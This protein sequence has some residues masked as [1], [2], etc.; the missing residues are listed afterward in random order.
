MTEETAKSVHRE[1]TSLYLC[2]RAIANINDKLDILRKKFET[3]SSPKSPR[4]DKVG[5][6]GGVYKSSDGKLLSLMERIEDVERELKGEEDKRHRILSQ[7]NKVLSQL[8]DADKAFLSEY[9]DARDK[10]AIGDKYG[11]AN[12]YVQAIDII[13]KTNY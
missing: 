7:R 11:Y 12:A 10:Q 6:S 4:W 3:L 8:N 1:L 2:E 9:L 13:K 5:I